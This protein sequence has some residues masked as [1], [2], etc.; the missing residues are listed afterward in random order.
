MLLGGV[1]ALVGGVAGNPLRP[2]DER[3]TDLR[4]GLL[5]VFDEQ[6]LHQVSVSD[7]GSERHLFPLLASDLACALG[8]LVDP[9][10][11]L[12]ALDGVVPVSYTHLTLPT[13]REV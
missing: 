6:R 13:N 8:L 4:V 3:R 5:V 9:A 12:D 11:R 1:Q 7:L 2:C 10:V